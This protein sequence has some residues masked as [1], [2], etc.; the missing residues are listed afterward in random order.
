MER[1][2]VQK[3]RMAAPACPDPWSSGEGGVRLARSQGWWSV[4]GGAR[5]EEYPV[6]TDPRGGTWR[7]PAVMGCPSHNWICRGSYPHIVSS[8]H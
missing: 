3:R 2:T 4:W 7:G 6:S 1:S 5:W 8:S